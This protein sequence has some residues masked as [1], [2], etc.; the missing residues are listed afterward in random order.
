MKSVVSPSP[1]SVSRDTS[2]VTVPPVTPCT[3]RS[4]PSRFASAGTSNLKYLHV[5]AAWFVT[6]LVPLANVT[7]VG[8]SAVRASEK[9]P[10]AV[11]PL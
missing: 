1:G 2:A 6:T 3:R 11:A 7:G 5:P 8:V 10:S 4:Q 9:F